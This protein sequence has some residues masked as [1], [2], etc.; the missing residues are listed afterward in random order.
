M[1]YKIGWLPYESYEPKE[2]WEPFAVATS[3]KIEKSVIWLRKPFAE[4]RNDDNSI[5]GPKPR[6]PNLEE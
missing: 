5:K 1:K 6:N 2:G 3:S 4:S